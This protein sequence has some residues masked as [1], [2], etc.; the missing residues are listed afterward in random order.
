MEICRARLGQISEQFHIHGQMNSFLQYPPSSVHKPLM[1]GLYYDQFKRWFQ[2]YDRSS[3][4]LILTSDVLYSQPEHAVNQVLS[5]LNVD[6]IT[7]SNFKFNYKAPKNAAC[8]KDM[9]PY[10]DAEEL[11]AL[12][13]YYIQHNEGLEELVSMTFHWLHE[14]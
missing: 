1:R 14:E 13:G 10:I 7:P 4:F 8:K 6:K 3:S 5:F 9:G 12:K 2:L 11:A